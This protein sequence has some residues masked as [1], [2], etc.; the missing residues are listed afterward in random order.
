MPGLII[1][2]IVFLMGTGLEAQW[3]K[4]PTPGIP[5]KLDGKPDLSGPAP[6]APDGR[7]DLSGL[8]RLNPGAY[9][10]NI[11][12]DLKAAEIAPWADAL[13]KQRMEDLGKDDPSTF[14]WTP[15]R[16]RSR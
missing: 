6:R 1:V 9:D 14:K 4:Q 10:G 12:A 5:R 11:V 2:T 3:L 13:Y 16:T 15:E 8:W 7:P